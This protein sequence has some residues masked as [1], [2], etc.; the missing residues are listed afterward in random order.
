MKAKHLLLLVLPL[1]SYACTQGTPPPIAGHANPYD[2]P[3]VSYT[4]PALA[5]ETRYDRP[6]ITRDPISHHVYVTLPLRSVTDQTLYVDHRTIFLDRA[7]QPVDTTEWR[8]VT[9]NPQVT[10]RLGA[11]SMVPHVEHAEVQLRYAK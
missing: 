8:R 5:R 9:L 6:I 4:D 11:K 10:E 1:L 7:G 3:Q 2:I